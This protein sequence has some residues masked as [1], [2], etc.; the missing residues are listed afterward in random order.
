MGD[1][2]PAELRIYCICGQKMKVSESMF[3]LPGKCVACRQR[4]R[5]PTRGELSP[6]TTAVYLKDRP[7]F[8][9]RPSGKRAG[10]VPK[11]PQAPAATGPEESEAVELGDGSELV[12]AAILDVLEPLRAL[13]SL[14]HK[15]QRQMESM[16]TGAGNGVSGEDAATLAAYQERVRDARA[17]LDDQLRQRLMEV[18]IELS[19]VGEKIVQS[20]LSFRIG[21]ITLEA[22]RETADRLRHRRDYLERLQQDIRGW[23]TVTDPHLAGGYANVSLD[24]IPEPGFQA[25]LPSETE[26]YRSLFDEHIDS[27]REALARRARAELR[28]N[29]TNRLRADGSMSLA[30]L[31][32]CRA[33]VQAEKARADAEVTFRRKRLEQLST[34]YAGDVQTIQAARDRLA[35]QLKERLIDKALHDSFERDLTR[36]QNDC[37]N[38]HSVITRALIASTAQDVPSPHGSFIKRMARPVA[39]PNVGGDADCWI[40]WG[41]A[42]TLGL[43]VFLPLVDDLSPVRAYQNLAFQGQVVHW[44]M[45]VPV[46]LGVLITLAGVLPWRMV[47]GLL[48]TGLWLAA[49]VATASLIHA[50][51]FSQEPIAVRFCQGSAWFYRPG[52]LLMMAADLGVIVA[53]GVALAP[54]QRARAAIPLACG[55]CA[56]MFL[57]IFTDWAGTRGPHPWISATWTERET[58][59]G[60]VYE[61]IVAISN[62][63]RRPLV[64]G[65]AGSRN[66]TTYLLER[67]RDDQDWEDVALTAPTGTRF[68]A[69]DDTT[70]FHHTLRPGTYRAH[71]RAQRSGQDVAITLFS[72]VA[73]TL[74]ACETD[75]EPVPPAPPAPPANPPNPATPSEPASSSAEA[76]SSA[77]AAE[78]ELRGIVNA[79]A[80]GPRFS[81]VLYAPGGK[82]AHL[83]LALGDP[84]F[85]NWVISEFNPERQCATLVN[86][87]KLL[88]LN[89]G[90]R[91]TLP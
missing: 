70:R 79:E 23:L 22:F 74:P 40:A 27:L 28:M 34:D 54:F 82:T 15:L 18:A 21:E 67:E 60:P 25:V 24:A 14:S 33:D 32:D 75:T 63:G 56:A 35:R 48:L 8:L 66:A 61:T 1:D 11:A 19:N 20:G 68:V 37:A 16:K 7:E 2:K 36:A 53:A 57:G 9:R 86:G 89:R 26:H 44:V 29:E 49:T 47:R 39:P 62:R 42:V 90:Q 83:D 13:C 85:G 52:M 4:I 38:V 12:S 31:T 46:L 78:V 77:G 6:G 55:I 5:I 58:P 71:L 80:K 43:S 64:I 30:V 10:A 3:G 65:A 41:A 51:Q 88:I 59:T 84:V 45:T 81:A 17:E 50:A 91:L 69:P 73:T 76:A 87:D 72:P